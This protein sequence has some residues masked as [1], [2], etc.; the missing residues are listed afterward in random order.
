MNYLIKVECNRIKGEQ[1]QQTQ[2]NSNKNQTDIKSTGLT[3]S[4]SSKQATQLD[5]KV[6]VSNFIRASNAVRDQN[7]KSEG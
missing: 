7:D 6:I 5:K 1:G 3:G 4:A 2:Q